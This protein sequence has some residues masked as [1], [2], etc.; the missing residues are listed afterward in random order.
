MVLQRKIAFYVL[1]ALGLASCNKEFGPQSVSGNIVVPDSSLAIIV[2]EGNFQW[3][4]ASLGQFDPDNSTYQDGIFRSANDRFLGDVIQEAHQIRDHFYLVMNGSNELLICDRN[5]Q[6][7]KSVAGLGAPKNLWFWNQSLWMTDLF[8]PQL[9]QLDLNGNLIATFDLSQSPSQ[10]LHWQ[11]Q[12]IIAFPK[13]L[14]RLNSTSNKFEDLSQFNNE[15]EAIL[16]LDQG[17]VLAFDNARIEYWASPDSAREL[18][19]TK[20]ILPNALSADPSTNSFFSFDGDSLYAHARDWSY[21]ASALLAL[22]TENYYG[23]DFHPETNSLY[24]FDA[25]SYVQPHRVLR[26]D[27]STGTILDDFSAGALPNGLVKRW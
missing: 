19:S 27:A 1:L 5:W 21:E 24:L 12:L 6:Q 22:K 13:K 14:Q 18:I 16:E 3:G 7:L 9:Q 15:L 25:K 4:N 20:S 11:D 2:N 10:I 26:I 17:L 23:L 8:Q